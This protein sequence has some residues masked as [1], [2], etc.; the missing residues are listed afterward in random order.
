MKPQQNEM[1]SN[2][3]HLLHEKFKQKGEYFRSAEENWQPD[4]RLPEDLKTEVW[5]FD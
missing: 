4:E 5:L 3:F 2:F 1:K